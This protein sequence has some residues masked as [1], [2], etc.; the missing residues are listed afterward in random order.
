VSDE[1]Q[2]DPVAWHSE[3][4]Q[5]GIAVESALLPAGYHGMTGNPLKEPYLEV[6]FVLNAVDW[7]LAHKDWREQL[8]RDCQMAF[9]VEMVKEIEKAIA[10][11]F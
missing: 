9:Y 2:A 8:V 6:T 3:V 7:A 1:G 4:Q 5:R 11:R 10:K